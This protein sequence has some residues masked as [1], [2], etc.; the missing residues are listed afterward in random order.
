MKLS[1]VAI[2]K[3]LT[4][5]SQELLPSREAA[6][7]HLKKQSHIHADETSYTYLAKRKREVAWV[8]V[9]ADKT[10]V[11]YELALSRGKAVLEK[12][13]PV[14]PGGLIAV[15]DGCGRLTLGFLHVFSAVGRI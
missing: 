14:D 15:V 11:V 4:S 1:P 8:W 10:T 12:L 7:K 5:V 13:F 6:L 3:V 2:Q 9:L